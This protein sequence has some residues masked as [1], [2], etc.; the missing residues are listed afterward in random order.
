MFPMLSFFPCQEK[1]EKPPDGLIWAQLA[2]FDVLKLCV[3]VSVCVCLF[4][5][6][7]SN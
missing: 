5:F 7:G 6:E 2:T 4:I 3:C 1:R